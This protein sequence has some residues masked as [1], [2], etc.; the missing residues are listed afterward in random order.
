MSSLL[1]TQGCRIPGNSPKSIRFIVGC[2]IVAT[3]CALPTLSAKD[4]DAGGIEHEV[5]SSYSHIRI[6]R[7]GTVRTMTFVRDNGEEAFESQVNVKLPHILKFSYLQHMFTNYLVQPK[8]SKALIVGL[9][10]G[11]MVHFLQK[12]DPDVSIEA[13]EIDPVVVQ[14]AQKYFAVKPNKNVKLIIADGFEQFAKTQSK[15]DT[16]YMD[17]FLKPSATTD[18]TGVPLR[19]RTIEFYKQI[20]SRL[21]EG[22]T[23]VFNINP[24]SE[25]KDDL[26]T[27]AAAFPQMYVFSLPN[28]EGVVVV[29][30]MLRDRL[31]ATALKKAGREIDGRFKAGFSFEE[32]ASHLRKK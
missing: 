19:L 8:Q 16:I 30:S 29:G 18:E 27:I 31:D 32:I 13:V 2:L 10:G 1:P 6:R 3:C 28:S 25:M 20:Q 7:N 17:A 23:V 12:Y 21:S 9:G 5:K 4:R 24:H 26:E 11:S 14:L 22:G 15:Y